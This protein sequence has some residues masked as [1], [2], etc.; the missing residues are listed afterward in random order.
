MAS[1]KSLTFNGVKWYLIGDGA[2]II[3]NFVIGIILARLLTPA[4]FGTIG[5]YGVFFALAE[6][7]VNGGFSMSL[8]QK[9]DL[10]EL[11]CSTAF[12]ANIVVGS[13]MCVLFELI[14]PLIARFFNM[15]ILTNIIRLAA[16]G[17]FIGS[18]TVVQT[19][20][21]TK[22]V[23]F[24][25]TSLIRFFSALVAGVFCIVLAYK[26][27]GVWSL[28]VQ[29]LTAVSLRTILLW[30]FSNWMPKTQFSWQSFKGMFSF[31]GR[32]LGTR[33]LET[34]SGQASSF[35]LGK[36]FTLKDLGYYQKGAAFSRLLSTSISGAL[37]GVSFPVLAKTEDDETLKYLYRRYIKFT[38][39]LIFFFMLMLCV[40]SRPL[41]IF[42]YTDKW[43]I[44]AS[45]MQIVILG[46]MFDHMIGLNN[47][48]FNVKGRGDILIKLQIAKTT[49]MLTLLC[50]LAPFGIYGVCCAEALYYQ[51]AIALCGR[52]TN[53]ILGYGYIDQMKD[54]IPYLLMATIAVIPAFL[55]TL[56]SLPDML[57]LV[58]GSLISAFTYLIILLLR[59]DEVFIHYIWNNSKVVN[60]RNRF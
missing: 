34:I 15:P 36:A 58:L 14:S 13:F 32:I 3:S 26:G 8:V 46:L 41:I 50:M 30:V 53:K 37:F 28:V 54:I 19:A 52:Q 7:F 43:E 17:L 9:K 11:D 51:F 49:I 39:M 44:S 42:L 6:I 16:I 59:K 29:G 45:M 18:F 21:F 47:N 1:L 4:D 23:D 60:L 38:S 5:V 35:V 33:L 10:S 24:R 12:W 56:T 22:R 25:T 20:L 55:I 40:L 48:V 2:T 57:V 27:L 31:G